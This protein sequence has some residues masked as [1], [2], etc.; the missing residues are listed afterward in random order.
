MS[1]DF[2][3]YCSDKKVHCGEPGVESESKV[4]Y[5]CY[6]AYHWATRHTLDKVRKSFDSLK[7]AIEKQD[8]C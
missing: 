2:Q 8:S 1:D 7:S 5:W 3:S 4:C 6:R